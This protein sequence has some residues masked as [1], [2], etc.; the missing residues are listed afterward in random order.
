MLPSEGLSVQRSHHGGKQLESRVILRYEQCSED[1]DSLNYFSSCQDHRANKKLIANGLSSEMK[2][3][4]AELASLYSAP[5]ET[6][7]KLKSR[8]KKSLQASETTK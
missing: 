2:S 3:Y 6:F 4:I 5:A 7:D 8:F 1:D